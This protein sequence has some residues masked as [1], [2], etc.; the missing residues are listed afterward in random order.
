MRN[1]RIAFFTADW[2]YELVESTLQGLK[3]Y[4]D[5]H[6]NVQLRVFDCFGKELNS[7]TDRSE[8]AIYRLPDLQQFDGLLVQGNQIVLQPI[9]EEISAQIQEKGIPAVTVDCPIPGCTLVGIDNQQAQYAL[10]EHIITHHSARRLV[11]LTGLLE[12]GCPEGRQR[13]DGFLAACQDRGVEEATVINCTWRTSDGA[14]VARDW[15]DNGKPLPDA[16][17]CANDEMALG[18]MEELEKAGVRIPENVIVTGF[19]NLTSAE[20]ASPRLSTV[21]RDNER[22]NYFALQKLIDIIDGTEQRD[23]IPFDFRLI[24]SESCGCTLAARG[25]SIRNKF[26]HQNRFLKNFYTLQD[27]MAEELFETNTLPELMDIV[28]KNS[29]IFGCDNV[30][31]CVN[32]Y[33]YDNYDKKQ[34]TQDSESFSQEMV[35][36]ACGSCRCGTDRRHRH[37]RFP[38][39]ELLPAQV[40][41]QEKNFLVFY[42]LHYNTYSIGYLVMDGISEAAKLNLHK[43]VFSFLEIAIE[44]VR[45][46]CLLRQFNGMLDKL[47]VHDALTGVYNR[48]GYAR[49]G[50]AAFAR[51]MSADAGAQVLFIDM[52]NMKHINDRCGH[53][54]GDAAIRDT[55][56]LLQST[57]LPQDFIM[58]YGGDEFLVIASGKEESLGSDILQALSDYNRQNTQPFALSLSIGTVHAGLEDKRSLDELVQ[59]ADALMYEEKSRKKISRA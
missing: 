9:R 1:Y 16:F 24:C 30:Y 2:N 59:A 17:I 34:W 48:F 51:F 29:S 15:L 46:K 32:D 21:E 14:Q 8:Y 12:N 28:E 41:G 20:L 40:G 19:D 45:K 27:Q 13:R 35:L 56:Q 54:L 10:T 52:D 6:T 25:D 26:F 7:P 11:Y 31:L 44:N 37:T 58:R 39:Q 4:V 57:C 49:Y 3:Q 42:P 23:E 53:D 18:L 38:T 33:Y 36:A 22:L 50:Q 55:A 5:E 43:S 47:Y